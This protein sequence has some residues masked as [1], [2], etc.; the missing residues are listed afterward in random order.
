MILFIACPFSFTSRG[1][2][3]FGGSQRWLSE[4]EG[5]G[6]DVDVHGVADRVWLV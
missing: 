5:V 3:D 1:E 4:C 6:R 2:Q